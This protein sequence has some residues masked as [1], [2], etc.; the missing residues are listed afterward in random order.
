M[1][2]EEVPH[3]IDGYGEPDAGSGSDPLPEL[4]QVPEVQ[5]GVERVIPDYRRKIGRIDRWPKYGPG[6]GG[7]SRKLP[8]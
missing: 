8:N 5:P 1:A 2:F 6:Q 3:E 4:P 7:G